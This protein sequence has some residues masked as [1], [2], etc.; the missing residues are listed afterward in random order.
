MFQLFPE[1][2]DIDLHIVVLRIRLI[3]PDFQQQR[4]LGENQ[5]P[6]AHQQLHHVIFLAAQA[7]G[8]LSAGEGKCAFIQFQIAVLQKIRP[9]QLR[10]AAGQG[11]NAGQQLLGL[12]G[13]GEI[14]VRAAVQPLHLV[15]YLGA[16]G[17]HQHR[18]GV[19]RRTH[20]PQDRET[21]QLWQHHVQQHHVVNAGQGVVQSRLSVVR[22]I[23]AVTAQFQKVLKRRGKTHLVLNNQNP[24]KTSAWT[25]SPPDRW[26]QPASAGPAGPSPRDRW[27][28]R[29]PA[30]HTARFGP[31]AGPPRRGPAPPLCRSP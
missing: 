14:V 23:G 3:S 25:F 17:E 21:I 15:G 4:L 7:D 11:A 27:W 9:P 8:P 30:G 18:R 16:G 29:L 10:L 22:D 20:P 6:V 13:L 31:A 5:V 19:S 2:R 12:K 28:C 1:K 26:P 24:H